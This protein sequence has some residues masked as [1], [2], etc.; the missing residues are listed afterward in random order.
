MALQ[1][2]NGF[3]EQFAHFFKELFD[4]A[5][6]R[7]FTGAQPEHSDLAE[8]GTLLGEVT[9]N[10]VAD[11]GLVFEASGP[12]V[13]KN[14]LSVWVLTTIAAG[15]AGWFRITSSADD[16]DVSYSALRVDGAISAT[17]GGGEMIMNNVTVASGRT[18]SIDAFVYTL[19]PIL[20]A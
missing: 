5:V 13:I 12:Y 15:D 6:I 11:N 4:G 16:G 9:L 17:P 1:V 2:S 8:T 20:G 19:P 7:V 14:P 18:Y 10:G 3:K